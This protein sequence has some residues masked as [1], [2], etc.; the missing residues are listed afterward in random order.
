M[1]ALTHPRLFIIALQLSLLHPVASLAV[2]GGAMELLVHGERDAF[3][4]TLAGIVAAYLCVTGGLATVLAVV[5]RRRGRP[6]P[7]G[8]MAM[9]GPAGLIV[10]Y[11]LPDRTARP[12]RGF[13]VTLS[14]DA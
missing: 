13:A 1:N 6:W 7:W 3:A 12:G 4:L 2:L 8:L 9:V 10:V 5:A 11:C 14:G